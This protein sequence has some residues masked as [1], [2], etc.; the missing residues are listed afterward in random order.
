MQKNNSSFQQKK[1]TNIGKWYNVLLILYAPIS[2]LSASSRFIADSILIPACLFRILLS[3]ALFIAL[4]GILMEKTW[5]RWLTIG[6]YS[7]VFVGEASGLSRFHAVSLI[8]DVT[9][10][11]VPKFVSLIE[12]LIFLTLGIILIL[13]KPKM[14]HQV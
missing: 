12:V 5:A 7:F 10:L 9:N 2:G 8:T 11:L 3:I 4:V 1:I 6:V 14:K 13:Q